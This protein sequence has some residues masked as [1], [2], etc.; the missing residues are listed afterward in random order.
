MNKDFK[1]KNTKDA[2]EDIGIYI[3]DNKLSFNASINKDNNDLVLGDY[4]ITEKSSDFRKIDDETIICACLV[5]DDTFNFIGDEYKIISNKIYRKAKIISSFL[6]VSTGKIG[7]LNVKHTNAPKDIHIKKIASGSFEITKDN[8]QVFNCEDLNSL[9]YLRKGDSIDFDCSENMIVLNNRIL[10][11]AI[12]KDSYDSSL[13]DK[14]VL[15]TALQV[16][17]PNQYI[18]HKPHFQVVR[19]T[20]FYTSAIKERISKLKKG[21]H[22]ELCDEPIQVINGCIYKMVRVVKS[23]QDFL[24]DKIGWINIKDS[25]A[26]FSTTKSSNKNL[27]RTINSSSIGIP[28]NKHLVGYSIDCSEVSHDNTTL[29]EPGSTLWVSEKTDCNGRIIVQVETTIE[30]YGVTNVIEC[31]VDIF[32]INNLY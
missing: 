15:I 8:V 30:D 3:K 2:L 28:I 11:K 20:N 19:D 7:W 32:S 29:I 1:F 25:K 9:G 31:A 22:F 12:I 17:I 14:E 13:I 23:T 4:T 18:E 6:G 27:Q 10:K 5:K 26:L 24:E 21:D 16:G